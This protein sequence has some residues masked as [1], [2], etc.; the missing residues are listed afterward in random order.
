MPARATIEQMQQLAETRGGRCLSATYVNARTKLGWQCAEGHRFSLRPKEV[1][2][3]RRWWKK[4][5]GLD[6]AHR[7]SSP[8]LCMTHPESASTHGIVVLWVMKD[9]PL[10]FASGL[11]PSVVA[12]EKVQRAGLCSPALEP[13]FLHDPP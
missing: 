5:S 8:W 4:S 10:R 11:R 3:G 7:R 12:A 2:A 9:S 6:F 1:S 13:W